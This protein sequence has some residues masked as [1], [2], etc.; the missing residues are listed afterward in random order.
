MNSSLLKQCHLESVIRVSG[1]VGKRPKEAIN[2]KMKTGAI[3]VLV[4]K[5]ALLSPCD[6]DSLPFLPCGSVMATEELRLRYRYL[7][8]RSPRLQ[9]MLSLRA[10]TTMKVRTILA[11]ENFVE[12]E[13]PIL[14]KSTPEGARDY[15]VPS[16][17]HPCPCLCPSPV[18]PTT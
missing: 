15:L 9:K 17:L 7:D 5:L 1:T 11:Q 16:R 14:Y 2:K 3:E 13:T 12:V 4:S 6:I 18:S 8:L 10:E